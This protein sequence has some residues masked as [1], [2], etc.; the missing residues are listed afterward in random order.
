MWHFYLRPGRVE[1]VMS[2]SWRG[3]EG[4]WAF[5]MPGGF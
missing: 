5:K 4:E 3:V 2:F 1:E